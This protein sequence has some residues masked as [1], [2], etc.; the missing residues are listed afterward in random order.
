VLFA[1]DQVQGAVPP[2]AVSVAEYA[3]FSNPLGKEVAAITSGVACTVK[4][5]LPLIAVSPIPCEA[6]MLEL[7]PAI[8]VAKPEALILATFVFDDDQVTWVVI[9]CVLP[10]L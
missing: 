9:F 8:A 1:S 3:R 5:A 4:V 7:P 10:S 2:L 6:M